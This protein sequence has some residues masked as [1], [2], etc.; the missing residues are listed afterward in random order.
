MDFEKKISQLNYKKWQNLLKMRKSDEFKPIW[1]INWKYFPEKT[2]AI[3]Q[4]LIDD[5][6]LIQLL[7]F[8]KSS[9]ND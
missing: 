7:Y 9:N 5:F 4:P 3:L 8:I 2:A 1:A 6:R